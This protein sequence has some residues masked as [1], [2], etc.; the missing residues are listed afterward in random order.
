M[1]LSERIST[2]RRLLGDAI[3]TARWWHLAVLVGLIPIAPLVWLVVAIHAD[4]TR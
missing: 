2:A 4:M 1:D 3:R